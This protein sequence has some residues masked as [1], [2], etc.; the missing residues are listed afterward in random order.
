MPVTRSVT[1]SRAATTPPVVNAKRAPKRQ[2]EQDPAAV[3]KRIRSSTTGKAKAKS[4]TE[5]P[6]PLVEPTGEELAPLP[7]KLIFSLEE[8]KSHLIRADHRFGEVF[9]HLPCKPFERLE[10]IHPFRSV[11]SWSRGGWLRPFID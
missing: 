5:G 10:G 3:T 4:E 1:R 9:A 8:A 2:A 11:S 7:A 6:R